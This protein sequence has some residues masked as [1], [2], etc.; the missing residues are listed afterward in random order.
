M[1]I[2]EE[3]VTVDRYHE[4]IAAGVL[5]PNDPIELLE[6]FLVEKTPKSPPHSFHTNALADALRRMFPAG[7][8]V[9]SQ[10]PVTLPTSEP[11]P[12]I[13]VVQGSFLDYRDRHAGP[14]DIPLVV[15]VT[16]TTGHRDRV[17]KKRIY[18]GAN[19]PA[20]WILDVT[21]RTLEVYSDCDP[22]NKDYRTVRVLT[23]ADEAPVEVPGEVS[24][25][26]PLAA[27]LQ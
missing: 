5:T 20:Y 25:L 23:A 17:T 9:R 27:I 13:S 2:L 19:I 4:M 11:D 8:H 7:W 18:A 3:L 24:R 16:D 6:G 14:T 26:L 1:Q 21:S 22:D 15:E 10:E 12:D